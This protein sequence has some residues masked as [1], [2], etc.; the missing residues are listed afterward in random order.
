V[1]TPSQKSGGLHGG[2]AQHPGSSSA[3]PSPPTRARSGPANSTA[4]RSISATRRLADIAADVLA[5]F[6]SLGGRMF[7]RHF[8]DALWARHPSFESPENA[9]TVSLHYPEQ[10]VPDAS[11]RPL[12]ER[13]FAAYRA[14]KAAERTVD[15]LFHPD[16]GWKRMRVV[17]YA[18]LLE[19]LEHGDLDRFHGFL[20]NFASWPSAT[21]IEKSRLMHECSLDARKRRHFEQRVMAPL[22]QWWRVCGSGG[23]ELPALD[24]PRFG[25]PCGVLVDDVLVTPGAVFGEIYGR[26]LAGFVDAE[27]PVIGEVGGGYGRMIYYLSRHLER[28]CYLDFDLPETLCLASYFTMKVFPERRFLLYGEGEFTQD[29]LRE[30]DFILLPSFEISRL[31]DRCVDLFLNENSLGDMPGDAARLFVGEMCRTSNAVWHR[32]H[33]T[34]GNR[35]D[36]GTTSLIN[37]E[38]PITADF[39]E[40]VRQYDPAGLM[41][42]G[43]L[44]Y[45]SDMFWYYYRRRSES[46]DS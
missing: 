4:K 41:I 17:A 33:E 24:L 25:N 30:Y 8:V 45:D 26:M 40:I 35:F 15:P 12:V 39:L 29:S 43:R 42:Q 22:I 32:N 38:Y 11:E 19:G 16:G 31:P 37:R 21:G 18:P 13:L 44:D 6:L 10:V 27:R 14:A 2:N 34:W 1:S 3:A 7:Y 9:L 46:S 20:A 36:G 28:F 5:F 23:R